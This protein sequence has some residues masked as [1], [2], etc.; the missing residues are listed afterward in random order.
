MSKSYVR[1]WLSGWK[2]LSN[3]NKSGIWTPAGIAP[4]VSLAVRL[5]L[6]S[7]WFES[8]TPADMGLLTLMFLRRGS[9]IKQHSTRGLVCFRIGD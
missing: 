3:V 6:S 5:L 4:K 8:D 7:F 2:R 1:L 9:S